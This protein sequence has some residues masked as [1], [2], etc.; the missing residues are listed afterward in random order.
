M[1][2]LDF[3]QVSN[4]IQDI[5]IW[6]LFA[7]LYIQEKKAHAETIRQHQNDL[8]EIAGMRSNLMQVQRV[9]KSHDKL[10]QEE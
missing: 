10:S 1:T 8:R 2:E 9:V 4:L 5:G 6:V 3:S 7:W